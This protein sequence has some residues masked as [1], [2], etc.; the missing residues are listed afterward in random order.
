ME[1]TGCVIRDSNKFLIF[2]CRNNWFSSNVKLGEYYGV[3]GIYDGIYW[4]VIHF[5]YIPIY[6]GINLGKFIK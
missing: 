3:I 6:D 4:D 1:L 2:M 5:V